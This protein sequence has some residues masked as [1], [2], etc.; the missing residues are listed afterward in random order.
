M[1]FFSKWWRPQMPPTTQQ[2]ADAL[3]PTQVLRATID[4][5]TVALVLQGD[6]Q[7]HDAA[8][9]ALQPLV[10]KRTVRLVWSEHKPRAHTPAPPPPA[11]KLGQHS[12]LQRIELPQVG[13]IIA[14]ASGKGGVGKSTVTV[15]LAQALVRAGQRVC[16]VDADVYGPSVPTLLGMTDAGLQLVDN[17]IQPAI[18][19]EG[20]QM[21][22][23]AMAAPPG[24]ALIW[25]G[26]LAS[27]AVEQLL[28]Q[29]NI[30]PCDTLLIDLPPGTGDVPLAVMRKVALHGVIVVSTAS[31]VALQAVK[32]GFGLLKQLK[33]PV[34]GM[35]HT[36]AQTD[37]AVCGTTQPIFGHADAVMALCDD[38]KITCLGSISL[39]H[40]DVEA[41]YDVIAALLIGAL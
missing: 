14:V 3:A 38:L 40:G 4:A 33:V 7:T 36:M 37:C 24:Q 26:P 27:G 34:L 39:G 6:A 10:G 31:P 16:I 20:I 11:F 21:L 19:P 30:A 2:I 9:Q 32:R 5:H 41:P 13:R 8:L 22:S 28:S 1:R 12:T 18:S 15:R 29:S 25:R 17:K 35:V 23:L